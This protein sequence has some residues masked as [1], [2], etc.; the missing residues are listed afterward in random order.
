MSEHENHN[1]SSKWQEFFAVTFYRL[2]Q[3]ARIHEDN[4]KL[5][6]E[7]LHNFKRVLSQIEI[8]DNVTLVMSEG[9]LYIDGERL[10]YRKKFI[11]VINAM[12]A[13]FNERSLYGLRFHSATQAAGHGEIINLVR[14]L[15]FAVQKEEPTTWLEQQLINRQLLWVKILRKKDTAQEEIDPD[16]KQKAKNTYHSA[17]TSLRQVSQKISK[18]G[19]AGVRKAKRMIQSMIDL[20]LE[21]ESIMIGL[22]TIKDYDDYTYAHS[23]SV[24]VLS[25]CLGNRL[26][27]SRISLERLG[28]SGLF[29]DL[30]KVDIPH[31][32]VNKPGK[33][34]DT[35][36]NVIRKHPL[37]SVRQILK[38]HASQSLKS[39]IL[40]APYEHHIRYDLS[41]YPKAHFLKKISLFG[42]I[43]HITD[44]YD[45]ITSPRIYRPSAYSPD[46]ALAHMLKN[47]GTD[48]DP[49]LIKVF[50]MMMGTYPP[51]T[52]LQLDTGEIG[53][54]VDYPMESGENLPRVVLLQQD[55]D[56]KLKRGELVNLSE[57]D[58]STGTY[59]RQAVKTLNP[60]TFGIQPGEFI[61]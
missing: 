57:K 3:V 37:S 50:A 34:N 44:V 32:I 58:L 18:Q 46:Q 56:H 26:G 40:L 2:L 49:L 45:A 54:V 33:L 23:V 55:T 24:A 43:I 11:G 48:F 36:W 30:G 60:T 31:E 10:N 41:G 29:H 51:G 17:V 12:V 59:L 8:T 42:R 35:E 20:A 21:E 16:I 53:L 47:A 6:K 38:L 61:V 14:L 7:N 28:I 39:E 4:N 5:V 13:Y 1:T 19:S 9:R 15:N 27:L 52:L 25:L 22:S